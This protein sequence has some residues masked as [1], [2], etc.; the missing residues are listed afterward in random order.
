MTEAR[1]DAATYPIDTIAKLLELT[2]RRINQ[3]EN[4]GILPRPVARGRYE[5]VGCVQGYIRFLRAKNINEDL[6]DGTSEVAHR[7]RLTK[8]RADIAEMEVERLAGTLVDVLSVENA[9][10]A[11]GTRF[12][13]KVLSIP[14]KAAPVL[15]AEED[16]DTCC[17]IL[18]EHVHDALRELSNLDVDVDGEEPTTEADAEA[19]EINISTTETQH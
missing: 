11:A 2:P 13:Q 17:A 1:R 18:E 5:L 16:I 3:L 8:A 10:T 14:H 12:R 19:S 15:A 4:D 6:D 9:W 7:K